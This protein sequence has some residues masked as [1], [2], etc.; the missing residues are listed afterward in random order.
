[1]NFVEDLTIDVGA[2][3]P[4][5]IGI[6]YL[7]NNIGA[8]RNVTLRTES[9]AARS[10]L[11]MIRKW[12]GPALIQNLTVEG[13]DVGIAVAQTE[14]GLTF[15]HIRL[16]GQ[17]A[18]ALRNDQ[19]VL[20]IRDRDSRCAARDRQCGRQGLYRDRGQQTFGRYRQ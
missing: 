17:R 5:A 3:N 15:D 4:G 10:A 9:A 18:I 1:M 12:P 11:S 7:A 16:A 14:Y 8:V 19:N 2:G 20:A 13:F 6:D